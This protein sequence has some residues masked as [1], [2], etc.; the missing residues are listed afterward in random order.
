MKE[1]LNKVL[2]NKKLSNNYKTTIESFEMPK[3][4]IVS[5]DNYAKLN[6]EELEKDLNK[7]NFNEYHEKCKI[8]HINKKDNSNIISIIIEVPREIYKHIKNNKDRIFIG[9][10]CCKVWD[11]INVKPCAKCGRFGHNTAKCS[12]I[13][14]CLRCAG[15]HL[16]IQCS[17]T[18]GNTC[19]N[20][21]YS[22][23]TEKC[24]I[25]KNKINR[26][27]DMTDYP[28]RPTIP[29][30][31]GNVENNNKNTK[32]NYVPNE[33]RKKTVINA[34]VTQLTLQIPNNESTR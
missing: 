22:N 27:I 9:H 29:R 6:T 3:M 4:K 5:V 17:D 10:Q 26:Y 25:L 24:A 33:L 28:I 18:S 1:V 30:Y 21:F 8:L 13:I 2:L 32:V 14:C 34:A 23:D 7:R 15:S 16:T 19:I 11:L 12:N 31:V 20:C